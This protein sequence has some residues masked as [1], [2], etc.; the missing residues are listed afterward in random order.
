MSKSSASRQ[1]GT[2]R[3]RVTGGS[4]TRWANRGK[5]G[6]R[7]S[8]KAARTFSQ[9]TG[10]SNQKTELT[11]MRFVGRSRCSQAT[12]A[13]A[14]RWVAGMARGC[15]DRRHRL[16]DADSQG[17]RQLEH[18]PGVLEGAAVQLPELA[19]A[20]ADRLRV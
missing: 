9:S 5:A 17:D 13:L 3:P 6:I 19:H 15:Q 4:T 20:V 16:L 8:A 12:S 10:L 1:T 14:I 11:T 2:S 18:R 7:R